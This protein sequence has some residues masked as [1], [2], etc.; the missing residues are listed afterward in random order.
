MKVS[1]IKEFKIALTKDELTILKYLLSTNDGEWGDPLKDT[2]ELGDDEP[3]D[4]YAAL[5]SMSSKIY[6]LTWKDS[7]GRK[8]K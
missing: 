1:K 3:D 7:K 6:K 4:P 5:K 8:I 2:Y